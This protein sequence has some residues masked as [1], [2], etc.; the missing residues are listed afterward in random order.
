MR[1]RRGGALLQSWLL[2]AWI[3]SKL[4]PIGKCRFEPPSLRGD[5]VNGVQTKEVI[6]KSGI[7]PHYRK[8]QSM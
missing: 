4:G 5:Q 7:P 1:A 6:L 8:A 3:G 2:R